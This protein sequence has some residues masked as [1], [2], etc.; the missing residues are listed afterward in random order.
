MILFK[1]KSES[2][3]R[4]AS[5]LWPKYLRV[6]EQLNVNAALRKWT[7][8]LPN[9]SSFPNRKSYFS[10]IANSVVKNSEVDYLEFGV[11][12]GE[13]ISQWVHLNEHPESRFF[14]FDTFTGLPDN[15]KYDLQKG[16]FTTN[17]NTP[18]IDDPRVKFIIGLFQETLVQFLNDF[19]RRGRLVIHLDADLYTSTLF[20]LTSISNILSEGDIIM[21]DEFAYPL[22]EFRAYI[23]YTSSYRINLEPIAKVDRIIFPDQIAF[24]VK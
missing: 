1:I 21:F 2:K 10:H 19:K 16:A 4:I 23:D 13:S 12:S 9:I 15:W 6:L 8:Q 18:R 22:G 24:I 11:Y 7:R 14:G 17:G 5:I 20:V 3:Q